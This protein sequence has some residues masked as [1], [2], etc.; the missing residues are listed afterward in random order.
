MSAPIPATKVNEV[1][2]Y[3]GVPVFKNLNPFS[4][5]GK[6]KAELK[7]SMSDLLTKEPVAAHTGLGVIYIYENAEI[8][9]LNEF[10]A[11]YEKSDF[12]ASQ[13]MHYANALFIYGYF[14]KANHIYK[15]IIK[16]NRNDEEK[17]IQ[18]VKRFS[19]FCFFEDLNEVLETSYISRTL[20]EDAMSD[21]DEGYNIKAY[22]EKYNIPVEFYRDLRNSIDRVFY[23]Y[24][25][26]PTQADYTTYFDLDNFTYTLDIDPSYFDD[27]IHSICEMND[28]L[29]D[30]MIDSY[31]KHNI[32]FGSNEDRITAYYNLAS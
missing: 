32:K 8:Q 19:E 25:S 1:L 24:F 26:L 6:K 31:E 30:L 29:Q 23:Q 9:A 16:D 13:A 15:Q 4:P 5:I 17:F 27:A 28:S 14:D 21:I 22:L 18:V 12:G 20:P 11:A 10:K 2:Q 7:K 3:F